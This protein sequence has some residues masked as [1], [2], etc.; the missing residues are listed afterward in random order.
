MALEVAPWLLLGLVLAGLVKALFPE[1]VLQRWLGGRGLR[2]V[3]LAALVG[4]PLPLCSC[5]VIPT[6]LALHRGGV[7]R[8]PTTAFLVS[9][10]GIGVDAFLLTY[11]LLGPFMA[12]ARAF[13]AL[14]VALGTGILVAGQDGDRVGLVAGPGCEAKEA[15]ACHTGPGL[16]ASWGMRLRQGFRF[17]FREL[18]GDIWPWLGLGL[19]LAGLFMALL[20]PGALAA[21]GAGLGAKLLLA[22]VGIP[23]YLCAQ[24]A[25]PVAAGL[26]LSGA[27][28][29]TALVF[30]LA[31]PIA[32]LPTLTV[33]RRELGD[34]WL[35]RYLLGVV[36]GSLLMGVLVD[37]VVLGLGL[38]VSAQA[39]AVGGWFP[40]WVEWGALALLG[41]LGLRGWV[42]GL[43]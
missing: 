39:L 33:L 38:E 14:L 1:A 7:G 36:L 35:F 5:G 40:E 15:C 16:K 29:G 24:A 31:A 9:A 18:W 30:L 4:A 2:G 17:A 22:L 34:G 42:R 21:Y 28:P 26:V 19:V 10:P 41:F 25:T 32:S 37:G 12:V 20:P 6:A 13:S 23:L 43:L 27:S 3:A 11:A 8:G